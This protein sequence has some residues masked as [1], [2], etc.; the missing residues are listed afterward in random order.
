MYAC[1]YM[2]KYTSA[3][4][5]ITVYFPFITTTSSLFRVNRIDVDTSI[6]NAVYHN[7]NN[8]VLIT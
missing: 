3:I 2:C 4:S 7:N 6:L 1:A 5:I 8:S